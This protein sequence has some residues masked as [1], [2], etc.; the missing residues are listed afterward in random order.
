MPLKHAPTIWASS[1]TSNLKGVK[2]GIS[3]CL[4]LVLVRN[5]SLDLRGGLGSALGDATGL[6]GYIDISISH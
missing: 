3:S 2:T 1:P 6:D 4:V 5:G